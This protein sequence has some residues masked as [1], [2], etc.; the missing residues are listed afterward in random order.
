MSMILVE[1]CRYLI[2]WTDDPEEVEVVYRGT[3]NGFL[4]FDTPES[5]LVCRSTSVVILGK[6]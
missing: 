6:R 2:R 3:R 1:G 4:I 5:M